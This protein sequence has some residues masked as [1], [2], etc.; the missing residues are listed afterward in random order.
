MK[1]FSLFLGSLVIVLSIGAA[2]Y[3][4]ENTSWGK[5]K[6]LWKDGLTPAGLDPAAKDA[7]GQ[8]WYV[9]A[10]AKPGGN[11]SKAKPFASLAEDVLP[12]F[13][14]PKVMFSLTVFQ[15]RS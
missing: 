5:V 12:P 15:G 2:A 4:V 11:G 3:A 6:T 13:V 1:R 8:T 14:S 9:K 10:S 7:G